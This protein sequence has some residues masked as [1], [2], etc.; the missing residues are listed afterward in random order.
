MHEELRWKQFPLGWSYQLLERQ[1]SLWPTYAQVLDPV[2]GIPDLQNLKPHPKPLRKDNRAPES[3]R[4]ESYQLLKGLVSPKPHPLS[5]H[6]LADQVGLCLQKAQPGKQ[7]TKTG[8]LPHSPLMGL[9]LALPCVVPWLSQTYHPFHH[10]RMLRSPS[11]P[12]LF[13]I[14]FMWV[15][16]ASSLWT[17]VVIS[18]CQSSSPF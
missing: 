4:G 14:T 12:L 5:K 9:R 8:V 7:S 3:Q 18:K 15:L 1:V 11:P 2:H 13:I 16:K 17:C 10:I 6:P